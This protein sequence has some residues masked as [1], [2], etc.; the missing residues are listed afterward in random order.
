M[1]TTSSSIIGMSVFKAKLSKATLQ[2]T[3]A[4]K[5]KTTYTELS[6]SRLRMCKLQCS[7]KWHRIV[8]SLAGWKSPSLTWNKSTCAKL[9]CTTLTLENSTM[10]CKST[11]TQQNS[12]IRT[13]TYKQATT[14]KRLLYALETT[15]KA[16]SKTTTSWLPSLNRTSA[17]TSDHL[18]LYL[19]LFL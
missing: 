8:T 7:Q 18:R 9:K 1:R 3:K 14:L 16:W 10:H 12:S 19:M 11:G 5:S 17:A 13:A 2:L 6:Q 4:N 15:S